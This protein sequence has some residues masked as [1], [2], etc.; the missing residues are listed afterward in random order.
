MSVANEI[1]QGLLLQFERLLNGAYLMLH[2]PNLVF[3]P[4]L[5]GALVSALPVFMSHLVILRRITRLL[6][7]CR[8]NIGVGSFDLASVLLALFQPRRDLA[9]IAHLDCRHDLVVD[10]IANGDLER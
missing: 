8:S 10:G 9:G 7:G 2:V 4:L 5:R 6:G 3:S 1:A